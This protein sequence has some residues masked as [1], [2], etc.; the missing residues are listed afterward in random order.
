MASSGRGSGAALAD[1][2]GR[3]NAAA[4][5]SITQTYRRDFSP[6][7]QI[8]VATNGHGTKVREQ[9]AHIPADVHV[10]NSA[11]ESN[12]QPELVSFNVAPIDLNEC[13]EPPISSTKA[14]SEHYRLTV[15]RPAVLDPCRSFRFVGCRANNRF[16]RRSSTL[17]S[18][19]VRKG[20]RKSTR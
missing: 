1:D 18:R 10:K 15:S 14:Q 13:G 3:E 9:I 16:R 7:T 19:F 20:D 17:S 11:K 12:V 2:R 6:A 5:M 8:E 4:G